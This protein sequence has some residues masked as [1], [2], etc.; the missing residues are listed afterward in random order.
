M[1]A[2]ILNH[3][4]VDDWRT[5]ALLEQRAEML[6]EEEQLIGQRSSN[7]T[8]GGRNG[9]GRRLF[10]MFA[11]LLLVNLGV[12]LGVIFMHKPELKNDTTADWCGGSKG[13]KGAV[14]TT[15]ELATQAGLDI[16]AQGGNAYDAA[17]AVQLALSVVQPTST[18]LAG[19]GFVISF[20]SEGRIR[21]FDGREEAPSALHGNF[22]CDTSGTTEVCNTE[23]PCECL[24]NKAIPFNERKTGGGAV[25]VP[26]MIAM[27][28]RMHR[29]YGTLTLKQ[30]AAPALN[31]AR[32]GFA[33]YPML[34]DRISKNAWRLSRDEAAK[35]L[36]L[37]E[38]GDAPKVEIGEIFRNEGH[39]VLLERFFGDSE[40][41]LDELLHAFYKGE[42][43][44]AILRTAV[45][46]VNQVT[47]R[48][49]LLTEDDFANYVAVEREPL[50]VALSVNEREFFVYAPP[51]PSGGSIVIAQVAEL[52]SNLDT[53]S[54]VAS[55]SREFLT[56]FVDAQD[57]AFAD[58]NSYLA[59]P[60]V[61]DVPVAQLVDKN[62]LQQRARAY[63][64]GAG[65]ANAMD[66][67]QVPPG[68]DQS[69]GVMH[70]EGKRGTTHFVV[71]DEKGNLVSATT[72]LEE[73]MGAGIVVP[74]F[75]LLLNN[76]LTDFTALAKDNEGRLLLN[77]PAGGRYRRRTAL[78]DDK[79]TFGSK[80]PLSSMAPTIVTVMD[81]SGKE[82]PFLALGSPGGSRIPGTILN[83]LTR[84]LFF[85]EPLKTAT[86][87]GR[88]LSRNEAVQFA[89]VD[90][91]MVERELIDEDAFLM[92][93]LEKRGYKATVYETDR[94]KG[95]VQ[96]VM[97]R[98][99]EICAVADTSRLSTALGRAF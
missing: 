29:E 55:N 9:E 49:S 50:R 2:L 30:I 56:A 81:N 13:T 75:G 37:N 5:S 96:S 11:T 48:A 67:M 40:E 15:N 97:M 58:R 72:T 16:L 31:Y 36:Y 46:G 93:F 28:A 62:Y 19:G 70:E 10:Y 65:A 84:V 47:D 77:R 76:E 34:H 95:F 20:D 73:N 8:A 12:G 54:F 66:G 69:H 26:G 44:T 6:A 21:S 83:V 24:H 23:T 25:G 38:A 59:D 74:E 33:M 35:E 22:F 88:I 39:A 53:T 17:F 89:D 79:D 78:G 14:S 3:C 92:K 4:T 80:R 91:V 57:V 45:D 87:A 18:G 52:L 90:G 1:V 42:V 94:P 61:E 71:A 63:V 68:L 85:D 64:G 99:N 60:D 43:A 32:E 51:P 82:R 86:D 7:S 41:A 98:D 27:F